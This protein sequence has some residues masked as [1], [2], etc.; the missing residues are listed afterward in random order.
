M[1]SQLVP[2]EASEKIPFPD[3]LKDCQ[4]AIADLEILIYETW[5]GFHGTLTKDAA[6]RF[7]QI[8]AIFSWDMEWVEEMR[9]WAR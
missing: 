2:Y 8:A 1:G 5:E 6:R 9:E 7:L 3:E 4:D